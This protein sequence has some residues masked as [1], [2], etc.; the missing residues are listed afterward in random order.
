MQPAFRRPMP[1]YMQSKVQDIVNIM[2]GIHICDYYFSFLKYYTS[3]YVCVCTEICLTHTDWFITVEAK[4]WKDW[5]GSEGFAKR[6]ETLASTLQAEVLNNKKQPFAD[7]GRASY[8]NYQRTY[9]IMKPNY[10]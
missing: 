2:P 8:K 9:N 3:Q 4:A 1:S 6:E 7:W 10:K 5:V